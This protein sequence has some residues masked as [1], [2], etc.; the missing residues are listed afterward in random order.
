[1]NPD[2]KTPEYTEEEQ[3][4]IR[5]VEFEMTPQAEIARRIREESDRLV[6]DIMSKCKDG[7]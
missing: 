3:G 1:M 2:E 7:K 4:I 5:S 6:A